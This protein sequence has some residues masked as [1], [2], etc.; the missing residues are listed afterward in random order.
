MGTGDSYRKMKLA[1]RAGR[2]ASELIRKPSAEADPTS[3]VLFLRRSPGFL[4][5]LEPLELRPARHR[6]RGRG[7]RGAE[8]QV[9]GEVVFGGVDRFVPGDD[10][11]AVAGHAAQDRHHRAVGDAL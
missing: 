9:L 8:V 11:A 6:D 10:V 1:S 3:G 4:E 2:L 5:V 7:H